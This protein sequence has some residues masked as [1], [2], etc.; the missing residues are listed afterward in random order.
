M[1]QDALSELLERRDK[2]KDKLREIQE[3][4]DEVLSNMNND[5]MIVSYQSV[6]QNKDFVELKI[7]ELDER[8]ELLQVSVN[9]MASVTV[10]IEGRKKEFTVV[11]P[12]LADATLG[13]VSNKSPLAQ[14]LIGKKIGEI[15]NFVTP[16]GVRTC[17]LISIA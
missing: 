3:V 2:L 16:A 15:F 7:K 12:S 17:K 13:L 1:N 14:A 5:D 9:K 8:I 6:M 10:E 4:M 11:E